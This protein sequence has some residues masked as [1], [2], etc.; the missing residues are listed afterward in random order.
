MGMT[1]HVKSSKP[2]G[3]KA[4]V[5]QLTFTYTQHV[6]SKLTQALDGHLD[7]TW[8]NSIVI[9]YRLYLLTYECTQAFFI[10]STNTFCV[11]GTVWETDKNKGVGFPCIIYSLEKRQMK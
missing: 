9:T 4:L 1:K 5:G 8:T 2:W 11:S 7:T 10:I 3:R 6:I